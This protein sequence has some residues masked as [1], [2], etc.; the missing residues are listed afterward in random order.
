M[1]W[2]N[3]INAKRV[4]QN[5]QEFLIGTFEIRQVREF[6]RF[7]EHLVVDIEEV[8]GDGK[9]Y[10]DQKQIRPVYNPE[11]QRKV[12]NSKVEK[13]ADYLIHDS[14]AM[15]PTNIVIAIPSLVIESINESDQNVEITLNKVVNEEIKKPTGAVYLTI[16]DGQHR[17]KGIES[18]ILRL[19]EKINSSRK[20]IESSTNPSEDLE[21]EL[22]SNRKLLK[23]LMEFELLVTFFVDPAL[24]YQA[25]MFST[26]NKKRSLQRF[27]RYFF[28]EFT[29]VRKNGECPPNKCWLPSLA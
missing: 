26:I 20:V 12:N 17:I 8:E 25:M 19:E 10:T 18:A 23:R 28:M 21:A 27:Q 13:I 29:S 1:T 9:I 5:N 4:T 7:T 2:D 16:I 14:K 11:I 24:E 15:F 3:K 22:E 6:T